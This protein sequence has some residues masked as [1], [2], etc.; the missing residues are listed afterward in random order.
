MHPQKFWS[1]G[2]KGEA[3]THQQGLRQGDPLSPMLFLIATDVLQQTVK[4]VNNLLQTQLAP[5]IRELIMALQYADDTSFI[6][7]VDEVSIITFKLMLRLFAKMS[8]LD[9]NYQKSSFVPI[10]MSDEQAEK[11]KAI[12]GCAQTKF[13]VIYLG[14]PLTIKKPDRSTFIPLIEK[15]EKKL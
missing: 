8:G 14:M 5:K 7:K 9:I 13:P 4:E 10:N 12:L 15:M 2:N 1:T 6:V 3:F 11:V